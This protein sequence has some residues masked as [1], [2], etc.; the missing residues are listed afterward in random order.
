MSFICDFELHGLDDSNEF[1]N[2]IGVYEATL[3]QAKIYLSIMY[4]ELG[5]D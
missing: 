1:E 5:L 2:N 4:K 3:K